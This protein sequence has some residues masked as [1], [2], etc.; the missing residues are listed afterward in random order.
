MAPLTAS[1]EGQ[2]LAASGARSATDFIH[3]FIGD[4]T[5]AHP[6]AGLLLGNGF[7]Y[8]AGTCAGTAP[9]DGG[10][11][12]FLVGNG[13]DGW[14]GGSGGSAGLFGNGGAGGAGVSGALGHLGG[15]GGRGGLIWGQRGAD[16]PDAW[17]WWDEFDAWSWPD[18]SESQPD[19][20]TPGGDSSSSG[21]VEPQTDPI[22]PGDG[23]STSSTPYVDPFAGWTKPGSLVIPTCCGVIGVVVSPGYYPPGAP[24]PGPN[25]TLIIPAAPP[26]G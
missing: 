24:V 9:C 3:L 4:G 18:E 17:S 10:R 7:S 19:E 26:F 13:G 11:G 15:T 14:N 12:G 23:G 25:G 1:Q 21:A 20:T 8:D 22:T 6:N 16:G 5:A 2:P